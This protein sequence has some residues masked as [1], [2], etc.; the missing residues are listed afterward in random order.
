MRR[1]AP[2]WRNRESCLTYWKEGEKRESTVYL[3]IH[4][5]RR[6]RSIKLAEYGNRR[7]EIIRFVRL[8]HVSVQRFQMRHI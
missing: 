5:V 8:R 1:F 6:L 7:L 4:K 3:K 2:S